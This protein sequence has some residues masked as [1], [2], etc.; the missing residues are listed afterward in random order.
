MKLIKSWFS[1]DGFVNLEINSD[2]RNFA[3]HFRPVYVDNHFIL[4]IDKKIDI[5][6]DNARLIFK[7]LNTELLFDSICVNGSYFVNINSTSVSLNGVE[8]QW[9]L[10]FSKIQ[11]IYLGAY[12]NNVRRNFTGSIRDIFVDDR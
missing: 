10:D 7:N 9:N 11:T 4:N 5:Y 1:G 8:K 6:L 2:F 3:F 12:E